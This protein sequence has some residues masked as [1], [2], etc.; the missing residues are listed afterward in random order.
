MF[1]YILKYYNQKKAYS[2]LLRQEEFCGMFIL[3]DKMHKEKIYDILI[4]G[5]GAS[6]LMAAI[7]AKT[8]SD[9]CDL[10]LLEKNPLPAKKIYATGNGRCNFLN[11]NATPAN[12]FNIHFS[13]YNFK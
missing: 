12:Y 4:I 7:A 1:F 11:K 10:V 2:Q 3:G 8:K 9:S 5:A 13:E 6:G